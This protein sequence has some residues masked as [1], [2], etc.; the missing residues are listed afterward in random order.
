MDTYAKEIKETNNNASKKIYRQLLTDKDI[1]PLS[2]QRI[3]FR[4]V[5]MEIK[6]SIS[7]K[8]IQNL[9]CLLKEFEELVRNINKNPKAVYIRKI[10]FVNLMRKVIENIDHEDY[11]KYEWLRNRIDEL[12][13][14]E[15]KLI[16]NDCIAEAKR[17]R[18][19]K[20]IS[21]AYYEKSFWITEES[22]EQKNQKAIRLLTKG[23]SYMD[24]NHKSIINKIYT[25]LLSR[26]AKIHEEL[27][28][29][30]ESIKYNKELYKYIHFLIRELEVDKENIN[31]HIEAK[32]NIHPGLP[33]FRYLN[34]KELSSI[35][36][37]LLTDYETLTKQLID[38]NKNINQI[39]DLKM[40]DFN[41]T[42]ESLKKIIKH[43]FT[44]SQT[45]ITDS[46]D[47]IKKKAR[48]HNFH[49]DFREAE[50]GLK[51]A[52]DLIDNRIKLIFDKLINSEEISDLNDLIDYYIRTYNFHKNVNI[53]FIRD[54]KIKV[55]LPSV[56]VSSLIHCLIQNSR[57][58]GLRNKINPIQIKIRCT[59]EEDR[60]Y[61][62]YID[63]T[64]DFN[65]FENNIK[66]L[67]SGGT[68]IQ[69]RKNPI[70][71]GDGLKNLKKLFLQYHIDEAWK[72]E[73]DDDKK[74]LTIPL[75]KNL[76]MLSYG[77]S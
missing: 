29:W 46:I 71:G 69:S 77:D 66:E 35:K 5:E 14:G 31:L 16:L 57:E 32:G 37:S 3:R 41:K 2:I 8:N 67:N 25:Q 38:I 61:L 75:M 43:D 20:N 27:K 49:A 54:S 65:I 33:E 17:Y 12:K 13:K 70:K 55:K 26:L 15:A 76:I 72:L 44:N 53:D 28:N 4:Y 58:V 6:D 62:I 30:A 60:I 23:L 50:E 59:K 21:I 68:N 19:R 9:T 1:H 36:M 47:K 63:N 51:Q 40:V 42:A 34:M 48:K 10:H 18:D 74:I 52:E 11:N 7:E 73:G 64:K 24:G 39:Q 22:E 45:L 56:L